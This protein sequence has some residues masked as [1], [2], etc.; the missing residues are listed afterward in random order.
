MAIWRVYGQMDP[1]A[2]S[3]PIGKLRGLVIGERLCEVYE[4]FCEAIGTAALEFEHFAL[5]VTNAA[6]HKAVHTGSCA[7]CQ[8]VVVVDS[9]A[10][11]PTLCSLCQRR[12]QRHE[13]TASRA[14]PTA[15]PRADA[16]W[17]R[18]PPSAT[19]QSQHHLVDQQGED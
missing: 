19:Q 12:T 6:A 17:R 4:T 18:E 5:L 16:E 11:G 13:R 3:P 8:C 9:L 7:G 10:I 1:A 2:R 14:A 15:L